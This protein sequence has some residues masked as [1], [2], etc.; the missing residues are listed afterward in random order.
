MS[1]I[2]IKFV[3]RE[4]PLPAFI[5]KVLPVFERAGYTVNREAEMRLQNDYYDT[6]EH[7]FQNAK[8]GFRV[9]GFN[10]Q[11]EQT[12]KTQGKVSGGLHQRAEYNVPLDSA[13]PD[14]RLFPKDVW[15][16]DWDVESV[17][18]SLQ[19]Q[20]STNFIRTAFNVEWQEAL[21]EIVV[22]EGEATTG[23]NS[24]PIHEI[25]LFSI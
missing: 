15:P 19:R 21:V 11:F 23:K 5:D 3:T 10:D 16:E 24:S 12:M 1:E 22:D 8:M 25:E 6:A 2:E 17:N 4:S 14:L 7:I 18:E 20:F 13:E 9:R